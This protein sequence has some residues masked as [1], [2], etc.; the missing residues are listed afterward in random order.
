[1]R[2]T[3]M[4]VICMLVLALGAG[5]ALAATTTPPPDTLKVDYFANANTA[6]APD[7]TVRLDN[8]GTAGGSVCANIYV[9]DPNQELSECCSCYLSP[10]GLRTLSVNTDLTGN[11]LTGKTLATGVIKI[12]SN[13]ATST[14]CP[15]PTKLNSIQG[16]VRAWATHIQNA[17]FSETETASQDATLVAAEVNRLNAQ[18]NSIVLDGSGSGICTCGTGD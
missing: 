13:V 17:N 6:G 1:M 7:G 3:T 8:P 10:D 2:R 15:V 11:P 14:V 16:G 4:L 5:S 18:C 12:V 9:F